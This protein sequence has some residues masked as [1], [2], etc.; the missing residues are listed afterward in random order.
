M[1]QRTQ[2]LQQLIDSMGNGLVKTITG[3]RRCGKSVLLRDIFGQWLKDN[4]VD[5][6]H[7]IYLSFDDMEIEEL[8]EPKEF[9]KMVRSRISDNKTHYL[10]LD[11]VQLMDRFVEVLISLMHNEVFDIFVTGSNSRFL[12]TDIVTE[13]RGRSQEI[14]MQPLT[15]SEYIS[16]FD[17]DKDEAWSEYIEFGGLPQILSFKTK[18]Q[19]ITYLSNLVE[20]VYIKDIVERNKLKSGEGI[21]ELLRTLAYQWGLHAILDEYPKHSKAL[22]RNTCPAKQ[23]HDIFVISTS[24]F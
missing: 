19:K 12:S 22:K 7:I 8:R 14:R 24:H 17:G 10:L 13:F 1:V 6:G 23:W 15:F 5:D 4:G 18:Q 16:T 9:L 20:T 3:I 21:T 11:E 2:Y